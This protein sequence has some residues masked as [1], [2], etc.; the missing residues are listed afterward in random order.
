MPESSYLKE[1]RDVFY[2]ETEKE[3]YSNE[4][5]LERFGESFDVIKRERLCYSVNLD[6]SLVEPL[7]RM[8]PLSWG[9]SRTFATGV[10][11]GFIR[12]ND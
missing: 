10:S 8:T 12:G 1:L 11:N 4:H 3:M 7:I 6:H 2:N 9:T 5:T